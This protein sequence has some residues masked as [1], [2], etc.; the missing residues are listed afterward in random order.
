M[1]I[2]HGEANLLLDASVTANEVS[3]VVNVAAYQRKAI[4]LVGAGTAIVEVSLDKT[5]WAPVHTGLDDAAGTIS[6]DKVYQLPLALFY[7]RVTKSNDANE[8]TV[9]LFCEGFDSV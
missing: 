5:N 4:Q 1:R 6:A 8:V 2:N 3:A 7:L 9:I